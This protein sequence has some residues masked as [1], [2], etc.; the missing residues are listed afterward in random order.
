MAL[1]HLLTDG[2]A[3]SIF[4]EDTTAWYIMQHV[5]ED[6]TP[7]VLKK[8]WVATSNCVKGDTVQ[9]NIENIYTQSNIV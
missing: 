8:M 2:H 7:T 6:A 4:E 3:T 5:Y 1:R 9:D